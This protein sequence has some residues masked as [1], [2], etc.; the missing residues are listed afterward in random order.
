MTKAHELPDPD[1]WEEPDKWRRERW[2]EWHMR[3]LKGTCHQLDEKYRV[4]RAELAEQGLQHIDEYVRK[5]VQDRRKVEALRAEG[6]RLKV[7]PLRSRGEHRRPR[8]FEKGVAAWALK[9]VR[10]IWKDHFG[11][12][13]GKGALAAKIVA[14]WMWRSGL[15]DRKFTTDEVLSLRKKSGRHKPGSRKKPR[16][17]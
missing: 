4:R 2:A 8:K 16:A 9:A 6:M 10:E 5:K 7:L 11:R 12:Q 17:Q 14:E 13:N 15:G 1:D 3:M